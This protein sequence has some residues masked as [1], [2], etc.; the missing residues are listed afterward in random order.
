MCYSEFPYQVAMNFWIHVIVSSN[1]MLKKSLGLKVYGNWLCKYIDY[2]YFGYVWNAV[3]EHGIIFCSHVKEKYE[4]F[5]WIL[6]LVV[7]ISEV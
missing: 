6:K 4:T 5:C 3:N 1:Y 2:S 7:E